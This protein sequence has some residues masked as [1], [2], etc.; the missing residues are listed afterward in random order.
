MKNQLKLMVSKKVADRSHFGSNIESLLYVDNKDNANI[1]NPKLILK[2][3][4]QNFRKYLVIKPNKEEETNILSSQRKENNTLY[5]QYI[6]L[7][8][9]IS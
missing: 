7:L 8:R 5:F 6:C 1:K 4:R 9:Y 3:F 2:Q